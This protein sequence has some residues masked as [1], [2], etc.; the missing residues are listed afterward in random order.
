MQTDANGGFIT[1]VAVHRAV[2][3]PPVSST[4]CASAPGACQIVAYATVDVDARASVPLSFDPNGPLPT[5]SLTVTPNTDLVQ[6]Q[7]VTVAGTGFSPSAGAQILECTS[8]ATTFED[9]NQNAAGFAPV[10]QAGTFSLPFSV[11][12]ILHLTS[13]DVDCAS[14]PGACSLFASTYGSTSVV[15]RAALDFDASVPPPLR[16]PHGHPRH[17]PRPGSVDRRHRQQLPARARRSASAS[18]PPAG[19][20]VARAASGSPASWSPTTPAASARR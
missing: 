4:D 12:R 16:R 19:G 6:Y 20:S 2:V 1:T 15:A 10:S 11:R 7:S 8:D 9:C 14:S 5:G 13:G 3:E 18:A 17:R